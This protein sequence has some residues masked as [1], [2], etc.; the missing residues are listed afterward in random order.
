MRNNVWVLEEQL[1]QERA[2]PGAAECPDC[3]ATL[4][5]DDCEALLSCE[6]CG[7]VGKLSPL[8]APEEPE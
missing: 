2:I 6:S 8:V 5:P 1:R 3:G 7:W 4:F